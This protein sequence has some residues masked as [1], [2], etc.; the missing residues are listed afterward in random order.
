MKQLGILFVF[1][2][3]FILGSCSSSNSKLIG[4]W[5]VKS[6]QTHFGDENIPPAIITHI[7]DEQKKLSFKIVNDSVI[8]F[9]MD[10]NT[11]EG[12]YT[13][14]PNSKVIT[15]SFTGQNEFK[16]KLG[17]WNGSEIIND[18]KTPLGNLTVTFSKQ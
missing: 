8:V 1:S 14:N 18:T 13:L 16:N 6:V 2:F 17:F 3:I 5:K 12:H 10:N 7:K 15:Y 11:H 4:T 9:M